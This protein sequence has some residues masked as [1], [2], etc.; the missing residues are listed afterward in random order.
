[1][2]DRNHIFSVK[3]FLSEKLQQYVFKELSAF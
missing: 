1:M 3:S 2:T